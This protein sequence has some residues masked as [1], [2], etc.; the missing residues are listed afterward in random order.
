[1][2]AMMSCVQSVL[3]DIRLDDGIS[4]NIHCITT[5]VRFDAHGKVRVGIDIPI[6]PAKEPVTSVQIPK[7][8][9]PCWPR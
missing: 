2:Y 4:L 9:I 1:M 3:M 6:E 7:G 5:P 8:G